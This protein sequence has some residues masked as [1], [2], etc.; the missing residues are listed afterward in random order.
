VATVQELVFEL[1]ER[2]WPRA[3]EERDESALGDAETVGT[4]VVP[5][6]S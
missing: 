6:R 5:D 2:A 1:I 4:S 3:G